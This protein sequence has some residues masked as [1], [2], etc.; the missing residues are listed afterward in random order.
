MVLCTVPFP[1]AWRETVSGLP[2]SSQPPTPPLCHPPQAPTSIATNHV[3]THQSRAAHILGIFRT[4]TPRAV[5]AS[6]PTRKRN[7]ILKA[8]QGTW[9]SDSVFWQARGTGGPDGQGEKTEKR[10]GKDRAAQE[11][12]LKISGLCGD[13][14]RKRKKRPSPWVSQQLAENCKTTSGSDRVGCVWGVLT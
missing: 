13:S 6:R 14:E 7:S 8:G 2:C 10:N 12:N 9:V 11:T 4:F 5:G 1:G 3:V